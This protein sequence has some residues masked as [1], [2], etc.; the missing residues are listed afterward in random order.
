MTLNDEGAPNGPD[1]EWEGVAAV[2]YSLN[3]AVPPNRAN[4]LVTFPAIVDIVVDIVSDSE[5]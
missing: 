2:T 3:E 4:L 1:A 5:G